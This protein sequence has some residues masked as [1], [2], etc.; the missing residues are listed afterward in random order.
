MHLAEHG[1]FLVTLCRR[2]VPPLPLWMPSVLLPRRLQAFGLALPEPIL[3]ACVRTE[4]AGLSWSPEIA[5]VP[6]IPWG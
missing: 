4:V 1:W 3:L 2:P 5:S 6:E